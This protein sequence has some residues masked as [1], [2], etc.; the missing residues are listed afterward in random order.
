MSEHD[1]ETDITT[2][3]RIMAETQRDLA[4]SRGGDS[5]ANKVRVLS[6]IRIPEFDGGIGTSVRKYREWR[7]SLEIIGHLNE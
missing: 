5:K 6:S 1:S 4:R 2:V 7:K 3:L